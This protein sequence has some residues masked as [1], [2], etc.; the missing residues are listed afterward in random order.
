[1]LLPP[2]PAAMP[3]LTDASLISITPTG[4]NKKTLVALSVGISC[5][6]YKKYVSADSSLWPCQN[7][8]LEAYKRKA[9]FYH[10]VGIH[11]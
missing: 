10:A 7:L 11:G 2:P 9:F 8:F 1:M 3:E 5:A 6:T 4:F